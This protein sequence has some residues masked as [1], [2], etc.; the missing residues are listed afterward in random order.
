MALLSTP[1]N[2]AP[3]AEHGSCS[4]LD[5]A[6]CAARLSFCPR[7]ACDCD[8]ASCCAIAA[9]AAVSCSA[10]APSASARNSDP[11]RTPTVAP[12][13]SIAQDRWDMQTLGMIQET[14]DV[15]KPAGFHGTM[16]FLATNKSKNL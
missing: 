10:K 4:V 12:A 13:K 8:R 9:A 1:A 2:T 14:M 6:S 5:R 15:E 3:M 16:S 7:A 11:A